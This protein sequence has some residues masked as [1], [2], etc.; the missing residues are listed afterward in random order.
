MQ[1]LMDLESRVMLQNYK[2]FPV[3]FSHG[4][5]AYLYDQEGKKYLDFLAGIAVNAL[6]YAH[7][8]QVKGLQEQVGKLLH[9]SNYYYN[10]PAVKLAE[11]LT[12]QAFPGRVFFCNSGTEANEAALKLA[13]KYGKTR[14]AKPRTKVI[15]LLNSFHGRTIGSLAATGQP[16]YQDA[17][18][19]MPEGFVYAP[20]NDFAAL[21]ELADDETCAVILEPIL[22][23]SGVHPCHT[24]YLKEVR[25]FCTEN[26]ILL[27]FD[28]V[29]TGI[30][31][32][33][34]LFAYQAYGVE[35][36]L[37]S[38]AKGLGGGV[39]IGAVYLKEDLADILVPGDH[40]T[41][42][43]GNPLACQAGLIV[44]KAV[45]EEG[46]LDNVRKTG[47]YLAE[48]LEKIAEKTGLISEIRGKGLMLGVDLKLPLAKSVVAKALQKG[49]VL[50][51]TSDYTL[52]LLPP[53]I[54]GKQEVDEFSSIL[55]SLLLAIK[56]EK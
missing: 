53:L 44:L 7:P 55:E 37:F 14:F 21:K 17:F 52:R 15:S 33:G 8:A 16:K 45:L 54:I 29:Q 46:F 4:E 12:S 23:E 18:A 31:R 39:P 56:E 26:K 2:R 42:F 34:E 35:P 43:G 40:G 9:V 47:S 19:P 51:A 20:L 36:D 3:V 32:T 10:E 41:T 50:N 5:G 11:L 49:L 38:L 22:G 6:G 27:I 48:S 1:E 30:G 25:E 24:E 13:R 28:E